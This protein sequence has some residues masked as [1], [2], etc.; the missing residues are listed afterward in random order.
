MAEQH[1]LT[2]ARCREPLMPVFIQAVIGKLTLA[3]LRLVGA[4]M[5]PVAEQDSEA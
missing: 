2:A 4:I 1:S 3:P 5:P